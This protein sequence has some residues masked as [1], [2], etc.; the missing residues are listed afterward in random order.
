MD[1]LIDVKLTGD[2]ASKTARFGD[3]LSRVLQDSNDLG[4]L[5]VSAV[6]MGHLVKSGGAIAAD[7][8]EQEVRPGPQIISM[9]TCLL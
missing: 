9:H 2:D 6:T 5:D 8:V 3:L 7:I 1:E 4:L